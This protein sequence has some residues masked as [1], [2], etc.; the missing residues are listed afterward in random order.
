MP[1]QREASIWGKIRTELNQ[2]QQNI[3]NGQYDKAA[4]LDR[5]ILRRIVRMQ[6]D[7]AVLVSNDLESDIEQLFD[8]RLISQ[9]TKDKYLEI[10]RYA[11]ASRD[12]QVSAQEANASY[13]LL[14]EALSEYMDAGAQPLRGSSGTASERFTSRYSGPSEAS[15]AVSEEEAA[16]PV[17]ADQEPRTAGTAASLRRSYDAS[18][19][20]IPLRG[21]TRRA[22]S[23]TVRRVSRTKE[24]RPARPL[25]DSER[26]STRHGRRSA[27]NA[28]AAKRSAS[29]GRTKKNSAQP[30]EI[31][32]YSILK[33]AIPIVCLILLVVLIRLL[34]SGSDAPV[35]ET[36]PAATEAVTEAVVETEPETTEPET[37]APPETEAPVYIVTTDGARVRTASNTDSQILAQL[38]AGTQ[39]TYKGEADGWTN[40]DYE[41]RDGYIRSDLI[42]P[43]A[44]E[45][46]TAQ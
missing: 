2:A 29:S 38:D 16:D 32:L 17:E 13:S 40:I 15:D 8:N 27:G 21:T 45:N 5:E 23:S 12:G 11:D 43:V 22:G 33:F 41:G 9:K 26:V 31:D 4:S 7:R 46:G 28:S 34:M 14:K 30:M 39:V 10:C 44:A 19:V 1:T 37:T 35:I 24:Q 42:Q 18:G 36:T 6:V 20:D 3:L 25:R